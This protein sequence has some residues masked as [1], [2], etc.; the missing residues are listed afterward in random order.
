[1]DRQT[2]SSEEALGP[3]WSRCLDLA[4]EGMSAG[5]LGISTVI[6]TPE[7]E[8][9][10]AGRN[11]S[12]DREESCNLIRGNF[13]SHAELNAIATLQ[14]PS[15][16]RRDLILYATVEPCPMCLGAIVMSRVRK[17]RVASRDPWA[18]SVRLLDKDP[19]IA[20]KRIQADFET[21]IVEKL[22]FLLHMIQQ[23]KRSDWKNR[24]EHGFFGKM[25]E[26]YPGYFP[27]IGLLAGDDGFADDLRKKDKERIYTRIRDM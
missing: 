7:G 23:W 14:G 1:L 2:M 4:L 18:G 19:Y 24:K 6:T 10:S 15:T 11:Q 26:Q 13:V 5:S 16:E 8:V 22:F 25:E 27:L 9:L 21:G 12:H 20:G 17:V 3:V